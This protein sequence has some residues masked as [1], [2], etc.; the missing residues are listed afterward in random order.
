MKVERVNLYDYFGLKK[1]KEQSGYLNIYQQGISKYYPTRVRPAIIVIA[2][3]GYSG[4]CE[5]E[6]EPIALAY[7]AKGYN[8]FTLEYSCAPNVYPTQ[9]IEGCM[10][11]AFV[12]DNAERLC[13][14]PHQVAVA[15]FSAGGHLAGMTATLF[16]ESCVQEILKD[17]KSLSRPDAVILGYPVI[18]SGTFAH[19][20]SIEN[21]TG[22][23][24]DLYDKVS[25]E[26]Q[27]KE[28]SVP[29]FIWGTVNDDLV[30]SENAFSY[31]YACK[32]KG[33]EFEFHL[34]ENGRHGL[35]L[36]NEQTA[37]PEGR[38]LNSTVEEYIRPDVSTW[39]ELSVT[40]LK[41]RG[42]KIED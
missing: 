28:N 42:F 31:A 17:K 23:A 37:T 33:V 26:K 12:K 20:E 13:I 27:V 18:S 10:A 9:L 35:G 29:A 19:Q 24:S 3:G 40:W 1:E 11:V 32:K 6:G 39:F 15:G 41:N 8:V 4:I 38:V 2:G 16:E 14:N 36:A 22:G 5:R 34:Y 21:L 25:L 30:P 7:L